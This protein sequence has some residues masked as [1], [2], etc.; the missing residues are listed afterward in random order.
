MKFY[1][2][3]GKTQTQIGGSVDYLT[4]GSFTAKLNLPSDMSLGSYQLKIVAQKP[5]GM[6]NS[7]YSQSWINVTHSQSWFS[8]TI[9]VTKG[10]EERFAT[11]RRI[12]GQNIE[13]RAT[14][15]VIHGMNG[16]PWGNNA[17]L[18]SA[19]DNYQ[20]GDQVFTLDWSEAAKSSGMIFIDEGIIPDPY[21]GGNWIPGVAR[22]AVNTLTNK[23]GISSSNINLVGHS[24]GAYVAYEISKQIGG[25]GK[26]VA[27]DPAIT[28]NGGYTDEPNV[29]FSKYSQWSWGF[30]SS[31]LG[32]EDRSKTAHESF[33]LEFPWTGLSEGHGA[34]VKLWT[35]MLGNQNGSV[36]QYFGLDDMHSSGKPWKIDTW[37]IGSGWEAKI[38]AMDT[39]P[40]WGEE[41]ANWVPVQGGLKEI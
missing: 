14:W 18:A 20:T 17:N 29:N 26:L 28:T 1:V 10:G 13:N 35:N 5:S 32:H 27:L 31:K 38:E 25:V 34:G 40:G 19:I 21:L 11:F 15:I 9:G 24:L 2:V 7:F 36:S 16:N 4:D 30:Y 37:G 39:D 23:W 33:Q 41:K 8:D 6:S 3:N 22:F 12:D